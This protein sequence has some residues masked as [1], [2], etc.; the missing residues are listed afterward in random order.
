M[1]LV[2]RREAAHSFSIAQQFQQRQRDDLG[3]LF[4]VIEPEPFVSAVR[5]CLKHGPRASAIEHRGDAG[6]G[7]MSSVGI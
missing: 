3:R 5:V 6:C 1:L 2:G 4:E 7:V